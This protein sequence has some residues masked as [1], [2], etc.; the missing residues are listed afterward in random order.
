MTYQDVIEGFQKKISQCIDEDSD[1]RPDLPVCAED[2]RGVV[3]V[4]DDA[5]KLLIKR[6]E[7]LEATNFLHSK[8]RN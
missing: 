2:I 3:W 4:R 6:I 1:P 7:D 5:V 8:L